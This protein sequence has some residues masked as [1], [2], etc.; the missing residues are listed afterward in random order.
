MRAL[1][2]EIEFIKLL[3]SLGNG[4]TKIFQELG[5]N[6][7]EIS[8]RLIAIPANKKENIYI[9]NNIHNLEIM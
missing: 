8:I 4:V 3:K 6:V 7:I 5:E 9:P 2:H 1:H